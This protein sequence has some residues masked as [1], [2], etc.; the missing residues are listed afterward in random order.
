MEKENSSYKVIAFKGIDLKN[1]FRNMIYSKWLR[2]LRHGNDYF[3]LIQSDIYYEVYQKYIDLILNRPST[4]IRIAVLT[5]A[6]DV[7]LGFSVSEGSKLHY[8]HV[9]KDLRRQ[10]IARS[11]VPFDIEVIT[12]LT[13]MSM[14]IWSAKA[15]K[16][17]FNPF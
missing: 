3:K 13:K 11:L 2:S 1:Q 12:H 7:A 10:G 14:P 17:I 9:H 5:D 16:A 8:I 15:P 6:N 4:I